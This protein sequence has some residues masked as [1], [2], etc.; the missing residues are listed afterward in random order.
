MEVAPT[1][2]AEAPSAGPVHANT[3]DYV[4]R[5]PLR[6][7]ADRIAAKREAAA[8]EAETPEQ[9]IKHRAPD[10]KFASATE[11]PP[12]EGDAA[13]EVEI[14][15]SSE[16][17]V[18]DEPA[19]VPA[20]DPP[21]SWTKEEKAEFATYPREAQ[22][23]IARREQERERATHR[24]LT[25]AAER[26]KVLMAKEQAAEQ[27]RQQFEGAL[28]STI[29][30]LVDVQAQEFAEIKTPAD[31]QRLA[32]D[33]PFAYVRFKASQEKIQLL[34]Q[35]SITL[36]QQRAQQA[37]ENYAKWAEAQDK[38]FD[39]QAKEF[40][41][42][43]KGSEARKQVVSY[44]TEVRGLP[45][46]R[47]GRLWSGQEPLYLRDAAVQMVVRDAAKWHAAQKNAVTAAKKPVPT[48]MRP[49][50][51]PSKGDAAQADIKKLTEQVKT[52][53]T[54]RDQLYAAAALRAAKRAIGK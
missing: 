18:Q 43:E 45:Q 53:K 40:G 42:P 47:L 46:D 20:I 29:A 37:Q 34:H 36:Q 15:A 35:Q 14:P 9:P 2:G 13:P 32:N 44:L 30:Q 27:A 6:E 1:T 51:A 50:T 19:A 31:L 17:A 28:Q 4:A 22:E 54:D 16:T 25:E 24:S 23:R 11:S 10:G 5:D 7:A 39:K 8:K 12:Q 3:P 52:A 21:A 49:G 48:V 41:D 38:A 33:D 26:S